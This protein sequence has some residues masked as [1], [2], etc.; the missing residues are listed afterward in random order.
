M[1]SSS[2]ERE[3]IFYPFAVVDNLP[4]CISV[5]PDSMPL[6]ISKLPFIAITIFVKHHSIAHLIFFEPSIKRSAIIKLILPD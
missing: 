2:S 6:T 5:E 4:S 1:H 3:L